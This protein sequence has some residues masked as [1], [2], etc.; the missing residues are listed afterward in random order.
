MSSASIRQH[1][2]V[3]GGGGRAAVDALG[4]AAAHME[5]ESLAE[6]IRTG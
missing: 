4:L 5:S 1:F 6:K 2:V 3:E